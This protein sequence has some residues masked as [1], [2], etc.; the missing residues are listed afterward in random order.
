MATVTE[1]TILGRI[2]QSDESTLAPE[3]ARAILDWRF[4]RSDRNRMT[5]LLD[6]AKSGQLTKSERAEAESYERV[7]QLLSILK[8]KARISLQQ[9]ADRE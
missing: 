3:V 4:G 8:S 1:S 9:G 5:E 2:I 7:G 6:K